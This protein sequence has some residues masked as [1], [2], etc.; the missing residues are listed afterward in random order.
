[1][2]VARVTHKV[3]VTSVPVANNLGSRAI[4]ARIIYGVIVTDA[5][6][7]IQAGYCYCNSL[8]WSRRGR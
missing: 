5:T 3:A 4:G 1:M 8:I 7:Y 6:M 2:T